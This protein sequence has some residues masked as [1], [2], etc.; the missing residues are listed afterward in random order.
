MGS[1]YTIGQLAKAAGIPTSTVRYYERAGLLQ[2]LKRAENNY[3]TYT[4]DALHTIRFI[5]TAQAA[6]FTLADVRTFLALRAG[7]MAL[8]KDVQPLIAKRVQDVSARIQEMQQVLTVLQAFLAQCH[9]QA[10]DDTC[11]VLAALAPSAL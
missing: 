10:Q 6:G 9:A 3:R 7:D 2:P 8:C 5:R 4:S 1:K 11:H